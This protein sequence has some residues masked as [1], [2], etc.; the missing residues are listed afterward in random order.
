M[1]VSNS[2]TQAGFAR[3][4]FAVTAACSIMLSGVAL[5][6]QN[7][8]RVN[9]DTAALVVKS[10]STQ[11]TNIVLRVVG[12]GD[13]KAT[14]RAENGHLTWYLPNGASDSVYNYRVYATTLNAGAQGEGAR[15]VR[16]V[17]PEEREL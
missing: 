11:T 12:S 3:T 7:P 10:D 2:R 9:M 17:L 5:A 4:F 1:N 14:E 16:S 6:G 15:C 13:F 8:I